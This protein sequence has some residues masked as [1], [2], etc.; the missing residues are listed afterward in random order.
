MGEN[1]KTLR[2]SEVLVDD[3]DGD[4]RLDIPLAMKLPSVPGSLETD[5]V[6]MTTW[7]SFDGAFTKNIY[8]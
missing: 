5:S 4:G 2:A 8:K 3:F 1:F 7:H 6:Y